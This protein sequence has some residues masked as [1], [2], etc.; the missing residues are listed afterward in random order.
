MQQEQHGSP[1]RNRHHP[2]G[3]H[4]RE[5]GVR[6]A[7]SGAG[8]AEQALSHRTPLGVGGMGAVYR[9]RDLLRE[10]FGDPEPWVAVKALNDTFAEYP[11]AHALLYSEFALTSRLRHA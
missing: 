9:A 2:S 1:Q 6:S 5:E 10:Q 7:R 11:D 8:G 3:Q 4:T